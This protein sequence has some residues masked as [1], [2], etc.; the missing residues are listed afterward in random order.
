MEENEDGGHVVMVVR[1]SDGLVISINGVDSE[2]GVY[3]R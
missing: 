3:L 1:N 2:G